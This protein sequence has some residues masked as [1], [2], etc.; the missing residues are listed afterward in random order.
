MAFRFYDPILAALLEAD[1]YTVTDVE[2]QY[3][4][5]DCYVADLPTARV[6]WYVA[7]AELAE[8]QRG[9]A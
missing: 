3:G 2:D 8:Y 7:M 5:W 4:Y 9:E 1:G 6:P